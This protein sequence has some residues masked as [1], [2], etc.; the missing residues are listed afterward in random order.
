MKRKNIWIVSLLAVSL[1]LGACS[2]DTGDKN[3]EKH[4]TKDKGMS[5]EGMNH[6]GS[7]EVPKD[8]KKAMDPEYEV[9]SQ[10]VINA[11]HMEGMKGA[12]AKIAGAY[13]TTAYVV[14]YTPTTGGTPVKHHKWVIQ[15]EI[16]DAG[17][18]TLKKGQKVKLKADHMKGMKDASAIIESSEKTTVYMVDY[19]PTTGGK[20]VK[21]HKWVTENELEAK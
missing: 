17:N 15:E 10:A 2:N 14:T 12:K 9:G 6:S 21:N 20:R 1:T 7:G 8:L 19:T 16:Q 11:D 5:H 13:D 18:K 4:E 3:S